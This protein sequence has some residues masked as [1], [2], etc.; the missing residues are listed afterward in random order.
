MELGEQLTFCYE[1]HTF[2]VDVYNP[3]LSAALVEWPLGRHTKRMAQLGLASTKFPKYFSD[4][5]S[6]N[7]SAKK[8]VQFGRACYDVGGDESEFSNVKKVD[9]ITT[10]RQHNRIFHT[11]K[12]AG[13]RLK[14]Y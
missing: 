14:A 9:S 10:C 7:A 5:S 13:C 8:N 1:Y 4:R 3:S 6:L 2:C 12:L 11:L